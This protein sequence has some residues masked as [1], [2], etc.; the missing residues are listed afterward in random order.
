M[1]PARLQEAILLRGLSIRGFVRLL[2]GQGVPRSSYATIHRYLSGETPPPLEFLRTA[3]RLLDLREEWLVLGIGPP[4]TSEAGVGSAQV[5]L[6]DSD[7]WTGNVR[8]LPESVVRIRD[9]APTLTA[10]FVGDPVNSLFWEVMRR[11]AVAS[12]DQP[13][14]TRQIG[15]VATA[16]Q[17]LVDT[18]LTLLGLTAGKGPPKDQPEHTDY[19][20][21]MLHALS[22]AVAKPGEGPCALVVG[23]VER[24]GEEPKEAEN[25]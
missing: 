22:L 5:E 13:L 16:I 25:A 8:W 17:S 4:P 1:L 15:A 21:A 20:V 7:F 10:G 6:P 2:E 14:G 11:V 24:H 9:H 19:L 3:A 23:L 18:P 12:E